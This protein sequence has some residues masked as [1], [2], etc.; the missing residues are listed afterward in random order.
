M[1]DRKRRK[2]SIR[3]SFTRARNYINWSK[4]AFSKW[5]SHMWQMNLNYVANEIQY[6]LDYLKDIQ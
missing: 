3:Y 1:I 5:D 4:N 6:V 2:R